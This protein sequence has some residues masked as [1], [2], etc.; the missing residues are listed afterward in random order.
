MPSFHFSRARRALL[1]GAITASA[2]IAN[3]QQTLAPAGASAPSTFTI[4]LRAM[5]IGTEQVTV[6]RTASGWT[7]SGDGRLGPPLDVVTRN[8]DVRYGPDWQPLSLFIDASTRGQVTTLRTT[9]T[10]TSASN[11]ITTGTTGSGQVH[12][13][14]EAALLLPNL[15]FAP[16]EALSAR[17]RDA[18]PGATLPAYIAPLGSATITVGAPTEEQIQTVSRVIKVQR[19]PITLAVPTGPPVTGEIWGDESGRLLRVSI[20]AQSLEVVREDIAS[21]SSRRVVV[22]RQNDEQVRVA[23][24]GFSIAGT[25]AKPAG[26]DGKPRPAVVL[27]SGSGPTDRDETIAGIPVFGQIA[28]ALA[29]AGFYVLR[30]DKRGVGQSGGRPEAATLDD[31]AEDLRAAVRFLAGRQ[32]V[33][34]RRIAVVGYADGGP[35]ALIAAAKEDRITAAA[36]IASIG[37]KGADANLA[38]VTRALERSKQ[39]DEQKQVAM[40]LQKQIQNAVLTG[41]GWEGVPPELRRQADTPW[42]HSY[43]SFDPARI[44]RDVEQPLLIV[45]GGLDAQVA[46]SNADGL[47]QLARARRRG[48]VEVV[49]VPGVNHLLVPATTGEIDEYGTLPDRTVSASVTNALSAWL[50]KSLPATSR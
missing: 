8:I 4:F 43:L 49:R 29:D 47:E 20:P 26:A 32:D 13:I 14:D 37:A 44:L 39:P 48:T 1:A 27:V 34:R 9:V 18:P 7:I 30:Y 25:L 22:S 23:A 46:P 40:A 17:L 19:T 11:D 33:D 35:V 41:S 16:Y 12:T 50:Q 42:F 38:Q 5:P 15:V 2:G 24:N 28:G 6:A 45:H 21:V 31:Y 10:G 3:A 36:L